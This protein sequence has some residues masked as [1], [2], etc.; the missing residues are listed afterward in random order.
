MTLKS[1]DGAVELAPN[2]VIHNKG[3]VGAKCL[4]GTSF[5]GS[6]CKSWEFRTLSNIGAEPASVAIAV[7]SIKCCLTVQLRSQVQDSKATAC[8]QVTILIHSLN[9]RSTALLTAVSLRRTVQYAS[10]NSLYFVQTGLSRSQETVV[11]ISSGSD[12]FLRSTPN[13]STDRYRSQT[14]SS[15]YQE[16]SKAVVFV[17]VAQQRWRL[18]ARELRA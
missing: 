10:S 14:A 1:F 16:T 17:K 11:Q 12:G 8:N 6:P 3:Q 18:L 2:S 7:S 5:E 15:K 9:L 4:G 13:C